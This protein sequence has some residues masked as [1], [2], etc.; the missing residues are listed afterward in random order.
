M[1]SLW[2]ML[3]DRM[4]SRFLSA[5]SRLHTRFSIGGL[6]GDTYAMRPWHSGHRRRS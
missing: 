4:G 5:P 2:L 6:I 3:F 1:V